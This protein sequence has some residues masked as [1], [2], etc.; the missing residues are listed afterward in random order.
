VLTDVIAVVV[1]WCAVACSDLQRQLQLKDQLVQDA[2]RRVADKQR[3]YNLLYADFAKQKAE[4][5]DA[6]EAAAQLQQQ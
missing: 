2:E 4:A 5:A 6:V 1:L 3:G